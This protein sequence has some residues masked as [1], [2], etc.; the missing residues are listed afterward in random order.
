MTPR[1]TAGHPAHT[2]HR[3]ARVVR[4]RHGVIVRLVPVAAPLVDV[5]TDVVDTVPVGRACSPHRRPANPAGVI[6]APVIAPGIERTSHPSTRGTFPFGF[7]RQ[8][9]SSVRFGAEPF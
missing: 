3:P 1:S 2:G 4:R 6:M 9:K 5:L 8:A 7:C